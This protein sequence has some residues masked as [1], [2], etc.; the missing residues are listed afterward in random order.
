MKSIFLLADSQLLFWRENGQLLIESV[1]KASTRDRLK[2]A[3]VGASNGDNPDFYDI[4]VAAMEQ[5]GIFDCRM[6]PSAVSDTDLAF[7]NDADIILLAGGD[8][9]TG[10]RTFLTNGLKDHI[11]RRYFEGASLIG[12]SAGAVQLGL[13]CLAMDGY[14]IETFKLVP[15]IIGAHEESNNWKTTTELLRLSAT[16]TRAIGL[17]TGGGAIYHQGHAIEPLRHPLVELSLAP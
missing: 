2:A 5:A 7:L 1:V 13:C 8:V 10:W 12:I 3:Y 16:N 9:E 11:I 15:F 4:F 17:P 6:I 14:L